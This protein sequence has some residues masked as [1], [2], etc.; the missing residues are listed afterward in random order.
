M[1]RHPRPRPRPR[2]HRRRPPRWH[3]AACASLA[4][5]WPRPSTRPRPAPT[6]WAR[7]SAP[8]AT[9]RY[10]AAATSTSTPSSSNA[11]CASS[12]PTASSVCSPPPASTPT[13]PP[14]A[15]SSP[16]PPPA[17]SPVIYDFEN[18][19]LGTD[20]PPFF[21][22]V[23]SRFKFCA[24][25]VGGPRTHVPRDP[26][27]FLPTR[28]HDH[29]RPRPS[30]HPESPDD[31]ARVNPNTGTAPIF[32]TRRDADLTR[33]IYQDHPVLV[34]HSGEKEH[35]VWP[36]R[37]HTMFHMANA[38]HLFRTAAQ[39]Q[40]EG[41]YPVQGNH[42]KRRK[43]LYLPLYQ[44]RMIHQF[45][46]R[47]SSVRVNP[48]STHNPYLSEE[49]SDAEH[50]DPDFLPRSQ[51]WVPASTVGSKFPKCG[52]A[53]G[54]RDIA[55]PTDV[56]T[57][58]AALVPQVG[59]GHKLP[60]LLP[61]EKEISALDA[62]F[63]LAN[64]NS[65]PYD[66]V[67]RQKVQATN[68]TWYTV[69]QLPVMPPD[70]YHRRFGDRTAAD[71]VR[72]HVLRLTYTSHDMAPFARDLGHHGPPFPWDQ[73]ARRH[74][75]ARLDALYFHLYGLAR[76]DAAY[77]L[78]TFAIIQRQDQAQ[79]GHYRTKALILAYMNALTAGDTESQVAV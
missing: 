1:V 78:S 76:D 59:C 7:S 67:A 64:L 75:R 15:S 62:A 73:E 3:Q 55:R 38:S 29:R 57:V 19:R 61:L 16:S 20:L 79:F 66:Y 49:T 69:E 74:L 27:R 23:D 56:R 44:G 52:Y 9:T 72:D 58:I 32:R 28:H 71:L 45:D 5:H 13:R 46:H 33:R 21:A 39:L 48:D 51:Y 30:L 22:D 42:W 54:F 43:E 47:A 25:I 70:A 68:L 24:L 10:S 8:P 35:R 2:P 40:D 11:P 41:F 31:F 17:A 63:I 65:F 6:A 60:L 18:R 26:L 77:I 14:P 37:Y 36:I 12:N 4:I 50:R 53:L 34:D